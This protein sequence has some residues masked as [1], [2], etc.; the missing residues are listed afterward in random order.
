MRGRDSLAAA[1]APSSDSQRTRAVS[2]RTGARPAVLRGVTFQSGLRVAS[3]HRAGSRAGELLCEGRRRSL[4]EGGSCDRP[5]SEAEA[6]QMWGQPC[7][8]AKTPLPRPSAQPS[9]LPLL[10]P[11]L[12]RHLTNHA[13]PFCPQRPRRPRHPPGP[14]HG[15]CSPLLLPLGCCPRRTVSSPRFGT[16]SHKQPASPSLST[17]A[18]LAVGCITCRSPVRSWGDCGP[19]PHV[20]G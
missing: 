8:K 14:H 16:S 7:G 20:G 11:T 1:R 18:Q 9:P 15:G 10:L 12:P 19:L 2:T 13:V 17:V 3:S 5:E 4:V 6:A